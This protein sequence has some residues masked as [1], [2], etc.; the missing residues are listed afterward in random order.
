MVKAV[1]EVKPKP[2][3]APAQR[4]VDP[5]KTEVVPGPKAE[6]LAAITGGNSSEEVAE[7]AAKHVSVEAERTKS[8]TAMRIPGDTRIAGLTLPANVKVVE[9]DGAWYVVAKPGGWAVDPNAP[10][11]RPESPA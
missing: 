3:E 5:I 6:P 8:E 7:N 11:R 4:F 1:E 10:R 2:G 9:S